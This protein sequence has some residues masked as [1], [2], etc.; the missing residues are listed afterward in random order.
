MSI[1]TIRSKLFISFFAFLTLTCATQAE[2]APQPQTITF[3]GDGTLSIPGIR[4]LIERQNQTLLWTSLN[5]ANNVYAADLKYGIG[6]ST[7]SIMGYGIAS[8]K[9]DYHINQVKLDVTSLAPGSRILALPYYYDPVTLRYNTETNV[10]YGLSFLTQP[11][12]YT[13]KL[14]SNTTQIVFAV[15]WNGIDPISSYSASLSI[16]SMTV[17]PY[18]ILPAVPEAETYVM[19]LVGLLLVG[20]V[21]YR[22]HLRIDTGDSAQAA[23]A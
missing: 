7:G 8:P 23:M 4:G 13:V 3:S 6:A 17:T 5:Y 20:A 15:I 16:K 14:P 10:Q 22:R 21:S 9:A 19:M 1:S 18:G 12:S 2:A 11:G